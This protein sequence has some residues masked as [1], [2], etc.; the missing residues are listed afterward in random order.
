MASL[1]FIYG[2]LPISL[3][4]SQKLN[5]LTHL[6]IEINERGFMAKSESAKSW[7]ITEAGKKYLNS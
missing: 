3:T 7:I 1:T 5:F 6:L 4:R 2:S